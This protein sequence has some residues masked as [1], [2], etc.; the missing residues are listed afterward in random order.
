VDVTRPDSLD[1]TDVCSAVAESRNHVAIEILFEDPET[2][3]GLVKWC[4][5][6]LGVGTTNEDAEDALQ[7]FYAAHGRRVKATYKPG[8]QSLVDYFKLCLKRF[9]WKRGKQLRKRKSSEMALDHASRNGHQV[10][11]DN[12]DS[13]VA[14]KILRE[15]DELTREREESRVLAEIAQLSIH[16]QQI[17]GLYY[18]KEL[19]MR[20]VAARLGISESAAKVRLFRARKRLNASRERGS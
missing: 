15:A 14:Q 4:L 2:L 16:D 8:S 7:D 13:S 6:H 11:V 9:C 20:E 1:R 3:K 12:Q 17:L 18:E 19:P 5:F 10:A